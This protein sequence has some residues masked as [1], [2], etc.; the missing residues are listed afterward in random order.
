MSC[1]MV[2]AVAYRLTTQNKKKL[3]NIDIIPINEIIKQLMLGLS[4]PYIF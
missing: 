1:S 2:T 4:V 3:K